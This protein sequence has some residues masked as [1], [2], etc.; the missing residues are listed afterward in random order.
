MNKYI[1]SQDGYSSEM[2]LWK[3]KRLYTESR[4]V[5]VPRVQ[6]E[7]DVGGAMGMG[8]RDALDMHQQSTMSG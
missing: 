4:Q 1:L 3:G 5:A 8:L 2:A 7:T 6:L